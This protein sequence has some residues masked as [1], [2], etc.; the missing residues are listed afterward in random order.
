M[1]SRQFVV[2]APTKMVPFAYAVGHGN[3]A[4]LRLF[5]TWLLNA[6]LRGVVDRLYAFF[7]ARSDVDVEALT[8]Q[9]CLERLSD[10]SVVVDD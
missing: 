9:V 5:D 2:P 1:R 10:E 3:E 7:A 6:R 4:L 8:G